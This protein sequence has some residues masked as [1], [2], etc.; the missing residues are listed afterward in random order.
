M[1]LVCTQSANG[2]NDLVAER[3][4]SAMNKSDNAWHDR[5]TDSL[6]SFEDRKILHGRGQRLRQKM[7]LNLIWSA[8][9]R[10]RRGRPRMHASREGGVVP[11]RREN[12]QFSKEIAKYQKSS[13][14]VQ[15]SLSALNISQQVICLAA[16]WGMPWLCRLSRFIR[17][18]GRR[19]RG[20]QRLGHQPVCSF[21]LFR[22]S[23]QRPHHATVDSKEFIGATR[24]LNHS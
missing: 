4:R 14:S 5:L 6:V 2:K 21:E 10:R 13:V 8:L 17:G 16:V 18:V 23:I 22:N 20:R 12:E 11:R 1:L 15:A 24:A 3:F 9:S 19:L 7:N